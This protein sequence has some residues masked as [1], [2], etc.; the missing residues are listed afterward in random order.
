MSE[1]I[2]I[3]GPFAAIGL[4]W[5]SIDRRFWREVGKQMFE[6]DE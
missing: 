5:L 1:W 4:I 3:L 6:G 2:C